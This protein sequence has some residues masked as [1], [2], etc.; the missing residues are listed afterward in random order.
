MRPAA[1]PRLLSADGEPPV[2]HALDAERAA[3]V[4][5]TPIRER[6][7]GAGGGGSPAVALEAC[8]A[9]AACCSVRHNQQLRA[10]NQL[11]R[12]LAP[13][14]RTHGAG[15]GRRHGGYGGV[16]AAPQRRCRWRW[17]RRRLVAT[18]LTA[19]AAAAPRRRRRRHRSRRATPGGSSAGG[20]VRRRRRPPRI[21]V[22]YAA[23]DPADH[24]R[25]PA[26]P[27]AAAEPARGRRSA[28]L[29]P[30][31]TAARRPRRPAA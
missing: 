4:A 7:A 31:A 12:S 2:T 15:R 8:V 30:K 22:S 23:M 24:T 11:L 20:A 16:Y 13:S 14:A 27:P 10:H 1:A 29:R 26:E 3:A 5:P 17:L 19:A 28:A 21:D 6:V 18:R 9:L 25:D